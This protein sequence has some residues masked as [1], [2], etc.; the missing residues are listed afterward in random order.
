MLPIYNVF[1]WW[2]IINIIHI[3]YLTNKVPEYDV[4]NISNFIEKKELR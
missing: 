1:I 3:T 2:T 4:L